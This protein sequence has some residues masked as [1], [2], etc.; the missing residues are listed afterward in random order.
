MKVVRG[1][2]ASRH[3][4]WF[5]D[6]EPSIYVRWT[7][8]NAT[9]VYQTGADS[10]LMDK[11]VKVDFG[12]WESFKTK[13]TLY[14]RYFSW[15]NP[16]DRPQSHRA[17]RLF[18]LHHTVTQIEGDIFTSFVDFPVLDVV[19]ELGILDLSTGCDSVCNPSNL[20]IQNVG[21]MMYQVHRCRISLS[22]RIYSQQDFI[23]FIIF[24]SV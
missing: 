5:D 4:E 2:I 7:R 17:F 6:T 16:A 19:A 1:A 23:D 10:W 11:L 14:T 18:D 13:M 24:E 22:I 20:N 9:S 15:T 3:P 8:I 21:L 12:C